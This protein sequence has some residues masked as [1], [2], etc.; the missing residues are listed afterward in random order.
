MSKRGQMWPT[1][2]TADKD[3]IKLGPSEQLVLMKNLWLSR[4]LDAAGFH[5]LQISK[6][7]RGFMPQASEDEMRQTVANLEGHN[8]I[9]VDHD[10]D[11]VLIVPFIRLDS[12]RQ[13]QIYVAACRAIQAAQSPSLRELAWERFR[14][15]THRR[16]STTPRSWLIPVSAWSGCSRWPTTNW[17][18]S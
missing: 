18:S 4:D 16:S 15:S 7:A 5:P 12:S 2:L 10:T 1:A 8:W 14:S 9:R 11:E 17:R 6:W 3:F 13:P